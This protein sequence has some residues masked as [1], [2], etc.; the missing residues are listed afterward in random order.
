MAADAVLI[1]AVPVAD[2]AAAVATSA[3]LWV[4]VAVIPDGLRRRSSVHPGS[5]DG[6]VS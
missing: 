5:V 3:M 2:N 1:D 6:Q 4:I